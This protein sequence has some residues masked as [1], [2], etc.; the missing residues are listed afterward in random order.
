MDKQTPC[1]YCKSQ[2]RVIRIEDCYY[3]QC[4]KCVHYGRY[5]FLGSSTDNALKQWN[6]ANAERPSNK[7]AKL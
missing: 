4:S 6:E 1:K 7:G 5:D 2:P 3:A